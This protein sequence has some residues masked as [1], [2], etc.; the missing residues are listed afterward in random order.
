MSLIEGIAGLR[1][2]ISSQPANRAG[3]PG[4]GMEGVPGSNG[5]KPGDAADEIR[6]TLAEMRTQG[7]AEAGGLRAPVDAAEAPSFGEMME[8]LVLAVDDKQ[9]ASK[10]AAQDLMLGRTDNLHQTMI[11]MQ[12]SSVAFTLLSETR[13]KLVEGYK[14]LMRMQV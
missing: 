12:E 10:Q 5:L 4:L 14:E 3:Q 6:R 2:A 9:K 13:N 8:R 11:T 1:Q 7:T